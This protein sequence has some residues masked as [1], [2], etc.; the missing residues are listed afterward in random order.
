MADSPTDACP[1]VSW[2]QRSPLKIGENQFF[3]YM[4]AGNKDM[5]CFMVRKVRK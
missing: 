5:M 3:L 2:G 4:S 1:S